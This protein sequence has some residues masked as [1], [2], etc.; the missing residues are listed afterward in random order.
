VE[1]LGAVVA[2]IVMRPFANRRSA[3][4]MECLEALRDTCL[5]VGCACF[6]IRVE[7]MVCVRRRT[8]S[9]HGIRES[10]SSRSLV[11]NRPEF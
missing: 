10:F 2:E 1:D 3:E 4:L 5:K 6:V 9:T 7:L 8:R 11:S